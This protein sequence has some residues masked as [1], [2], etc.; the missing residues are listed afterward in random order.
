[1]SGSSEQSDDEVSLSF[2]TSLTYVPLR[3]HSVFERFILFL[4]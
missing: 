1:M 2:R 3:A 4:L